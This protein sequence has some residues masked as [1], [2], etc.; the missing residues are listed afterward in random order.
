MAKNDF[1]RAALVYSEV[2]NKVE[3]LPADGVLMKLAQAY[4]KAGKPQEARATYQRV[5]DEF[6]DSPYVD[7]ARQQISTMN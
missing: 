5:V 7:D 4:A 2:A 6:P 3:A 1:D